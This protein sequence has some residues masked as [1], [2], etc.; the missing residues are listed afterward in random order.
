MIKYNKADLDRALSEIGI[1]SGQSL[2][3][4]TQLNSLGHFSDGNTKAEK[5]GIIYDAIRSKV[6]LEGT[7]TVPTWNFEKINKEFTY[8]PQSVP[9][10]AGVLTEFVRK[11]PG[12]KRSLHPFNSYTA[13]GRDADYICGNVSRHDF[14]P[15]SVFDHLLS[16]DTLAINIGIHPSQALS[17]MHHAE[18]VMGVPYRYHKEFLITITDG[19]HIF[20]D[21]FFIT[22]RFIVSEIIQDN[23]RKLFQVFHEMGFELVEVCVGAGA[24]YCYRTIEMFAALK[25]LLA[26]DPYG[27]LEEPP[28]TRPYAN[29]I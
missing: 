2:F 8:D 4:A 9:S 25:E 13:I 20:K 27:L 28:K 23:K 14:G 6:G 5:L 15:N 12:S 11:L 10:R 16:L 22:A 18:F 7:I 3:L 1:Q 21:H 19:D 26:R 17:L 24:L 29:T